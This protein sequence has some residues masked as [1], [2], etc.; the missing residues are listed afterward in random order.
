MMKRYWIAGLGLV[1]CA[2]MAQAQEGFGVLDPS[3]PSGITVAQIIEK[4]GARESDFESA[5]AQYTYRQTVKMDTIS[6]DTNKPDGEYLEVTDITF[7]DDGKRA[8]HVVYAP[9]NTI[10]SVIL[11]ENDM[12][13]V[14]ERLPF[15][16]TTEQMPQ[17]TL[18]YLGKQ[19][20]DELDTYVFQCEPKELVKGHRY[21]SGK[22]WVDQQDMEI[23]LVNGINVPQDTR[24]GHED[25]SP[26]FT[27]YY[28]Q[29]DGKYW[30][31]TYTKA[32]GVLHFQ[33][34]NG[35]L[36]QDVHMRS[37]VKYT[38]YKRYHA[39]VTLHYGGE[40]KDVPPED[41]PKN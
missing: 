30:F 11:T 12:K 15:V 7:S 3:Q 35:A 4:V 39:K 33:A 20:V 24:K 28:Q 13:D 27:T 23:V 25:L 14:K 9:Q 38:D 22:V 34:Q 40:V 26:P 1:C 41:A 19:K 18:T 29:I 32:E 17:Y 10:T 21:L 36:S 31:P 2:M 16:L 37:T 8:E 6:D 5:R